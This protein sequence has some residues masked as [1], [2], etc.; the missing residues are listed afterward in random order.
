MKKKL[1]ILY[2][3]LKYDY[4][5][6]INGY[7]F[8]HHNF[9][10]SFSLMENIETLDYFPIDEII[11]QSGKDYLN[12]KILLSA[13]KN[14]YDLIF[15]FIFKDEIFESTLKYLKNELGII[16]LGWMADDHWRFEIF[17]K[18]IANNYSY[19]ITTDKDTLPK[20]KENNLSNVIFSQWACNHHYYKPIEN[21]KINKI[22]FVGM[23]Y[24]TRGKDINYLKKNLG[25]ISCWGYG[26]PSGKIEDE[27]KIE[28]YSQSLI[29][30]NFSK[31][32]NQKNLKSFIKI[33]LKK[34]TNKNFQIN[35]TKEILDNTKNFFKNSSNQI[36]A[37][38]FEVIGC[39]TFLLSE[40]SDYIDEYFEVDK[41]I[42]LFSDLKEAEEKIRYYLKNETELNKIAKAGYERVLR[43]HTYEKRFN[44]IFKI[45][46]V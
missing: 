45:I 41:E 9:Y 38:I 27:K 31:S 28:I 23:Y 5:D 15:F 30:L 39:K 32:S 6:K 3:G 13:K 16:T 34:N 36:K 46:N 20:Y 7:S 21:K 4:G 43:D 26:W 12:E 33:F 22:S 19:I 2:C 10:K 8:E 18:Y 25:N 42:V 14:R 11:F 17:T 35:T 1:K 24:G 37:R 29:N 40:N 44:Q